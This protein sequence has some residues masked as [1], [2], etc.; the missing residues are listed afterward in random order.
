[1]LS[2]IFINLAVLLVLSLLLWW[3]SVLWRDSSI[4]DPCWG[5]GF[6]VAVWL[7]ALQSVSWQ[8]RSILLLTMVSIWGLRLTAYLA[9]RNHGKEEDY[10]YRQMREHHGA[11]FWYVSLFTIFWLQA[12]LLWFISLP[13]QATL[14]GSADNSTVLSWLD[15]TG[16]ALWFVGMIFE[17]VG[18]LQLAKF[19]A[20]PNNAGKVMDRGLWRYTRHP[21][22]FGDFCVWWGFYLVAVAGGAAWTLASPA[23]MSF[24]LIRVSGVRLLEKT[25]SDRRPAYRDY[26]QQTNAFFPG[27]PRRTS[28]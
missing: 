12:I 19:K 9:W 21:N 15:M 1:M 7:T 10:R 17:S 23:L 16:I 11:R 14:V 3:V 4:V 2:T 18:D 25:I 8:S 20:N 28:Q 5:F 22:Y 26:M 6:V 27:P 24:L 13:L